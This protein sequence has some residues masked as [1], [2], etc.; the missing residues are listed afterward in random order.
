MGN[1][2]KTSMNKNKCVSDY[3]YSIATLWCKVGLM[4]IKT[5]QLIKLYKI[6]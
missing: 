4:S 2:H 1:K 3:I 6:M 5:G